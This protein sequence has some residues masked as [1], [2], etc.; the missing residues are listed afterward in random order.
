MSV[1]NPILQKDLESGIG[2]SKD[3]TRLVNLYYC[4]KNQNK[5]TEIRDKILIGC[6]R[7]IR[8]VTIK[9]VGSQSEFLEDAFQSAC[10]NFLWGL[11]KYSP[12]KNNQFLTYIYYW[13]VKGINDEFYSRGI[14]SIGKDS[15]KGDRFKNLKNNNLL[16]YDK[17]KNGTKEQEYGVGKLVNSLVDHS[18]DFSRKI[19][20]EFLI[21]QIEKIMEINL[22]ELEYAVVKLRYFYDEQPTHREIA[23]HLGMSIQFSSVCETSGCFKIKRALSNPKKILGNTIQKK[24]K[25]S[26]FMNL[27]LN[28]DEIYLK[29]MKDKELKKKGV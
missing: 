18:E 7:F 16:Y 9:T 2:Q 21:K 28:T 27:F 26:K 11:D 17:I 25:K 13:I 8:K 20:K 4:C 12:K 19:E 24:V 29:I 15:Y 3:M 23:K 10:M 14:I 5:K 6:I 1:R 22:S